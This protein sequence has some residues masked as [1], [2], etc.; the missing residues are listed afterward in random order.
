MT[1][2]VFCLK[3]LTTPV[4]SCLTRPISPHFNAIISKNHL[5]HSHWTNFQNQLLGENGMDWLKTSQKVSINAKSMNGLSVFEF[6]STFHRWRDWGSSE[7]YTSKSQ[8][9]WA[10]ERTEQTDSSDHENSKRPQQVFVISIIS[11]IRFGAGYILESGFNVKDIKL[12]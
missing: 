10:T 5:P 11:I 1:P 8:L 2:R 9:L 6:P 7:T 3:P 12:L 4:K